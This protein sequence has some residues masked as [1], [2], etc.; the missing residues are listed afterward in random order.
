LSHFQFKSLN[1]FLIFNT[2]RGLVIVSALNAFSRP[3]LFSVLSALAAGGRSRL[4]KNYAY[5]IITKKCYHKGSRQKAVIIN[6][7]IKRG[8]A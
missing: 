6:F 7:K 4:P 8:K 3:S 2:F 1:L 5:A